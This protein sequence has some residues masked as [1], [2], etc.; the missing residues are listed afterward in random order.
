VAT[1]KKVDKGN[2]E[3]ADIFNTPSFKQGVE[4][5][6]ANND[7]RYLTDN[8][9]NIKWLLKLP[10]QEFNMLL[11]SSPSFRQKIDKISNAGYIT[12]KGLNEAA[13]W[14]GVTTL[15]PLLGFINDPISKEFRQWIKDLDVLRNRTGLQPH[16]WK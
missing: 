4:D 2:Q 6:A 8:Y 16:Q 9:D 14:G 3:I 1:G 13:I 12:A 5:A 10:N 7:I 15:N 11:D